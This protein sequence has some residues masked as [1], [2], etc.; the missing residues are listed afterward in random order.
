MTTVETSQAIV[1]LV[2]VPNAEVAARLADAL[3]GEALA[4]CVNVLPQLRSTYRWQ[5]RVAHDDEQLCLVKTTRDAFE[6]L[7]ARIVELHPYDVPE[8]IALPIVAGHA[9]YLAWIAASVTA[10]GG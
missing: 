1:V 10:R 7:R 5:G 4:A 2:T 3:V 6:R 9:P 8:V